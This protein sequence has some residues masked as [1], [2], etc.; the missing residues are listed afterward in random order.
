MQNT[1]MGKS[2]EGLNK[3]ITLMHTKFNQKE[4]REISWRGVIFFFYKN[5][6]HKKNN[7]MEIIA[8]ISLLSPKAPKRWP[9]AK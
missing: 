8:I 5:F 3:W 9:F 6:E 7:R 2:K 4:D 1:K